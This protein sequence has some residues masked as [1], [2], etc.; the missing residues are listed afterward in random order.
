MRV[1]RRPME[2][3]CYIMLETQVEIQLRVTQAVHPIKQTS[4]FSAISNLFQSWQITHLLGFFFFSSAVSQV[5]CKYTV[6]YPK[7]ETIKFP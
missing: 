1:K 7:I 6:K 3:K 5:A 2:C 4:F